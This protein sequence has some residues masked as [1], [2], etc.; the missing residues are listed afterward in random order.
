MWADPKTCLTV[1]ASGMSVGRHV[2]VYCFGPPYVST[3]KHSP[4]ALIHSPI[5]ILSNLSFFS[6]AL[7]SAPLAAL[8]SRLITSLV[9]GHDIVATLSVTSVRD[10]RNVALWLCEAEERGEGDGYSSVISRVWGWKGNAT[11]QKG[12]G[13]MDEDWAWVWFRSPD[14]SCSLYLFTSYTHKTPLLPV[15][16]DAQDTRG[17]YAEF[18]HVPP[19][20]RTLGSTRWRPT[21]IQ[22]EIPRQLHQLEIETKIDS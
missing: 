5:Q 20:T 3:S 11:E 10:L 18:G 9:Y 1:P 4:L 2:S 13:E 8:S 15:H 14:L 21:P 22:S 6:S 12:R 7:T 16:R 19:R 17:E